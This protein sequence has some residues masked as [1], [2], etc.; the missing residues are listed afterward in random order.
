VITDGDTGGDFAVKRIHTFACDFPLL[1]FI[2]VY[3]IAHV[4]DE[5]DPVFFKICCDPVCM[6]FK[7]WVGDLGRVGSTVAVRLCIRN[8]DDAEGIFGLQAGFAERKRSRGKE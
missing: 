7:Y 4:A 3:N 8:Q 1:N 5:G 2:H 6:V